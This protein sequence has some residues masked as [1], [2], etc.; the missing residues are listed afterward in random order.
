MHNSSS[1]AASLPRTYGI[2]FQM[3]VELPPAVGARNRTFVFKKNEVRNAYWEK[4]KQSCLFSSRNCCA[5]NREL[6]SGRRGIGQ[7]SIWRSF[8]I[9]RIAIR[10][11]SKKALDDTERAFDD[12]EGLRVARASRTTHECDAR[13]W[14]W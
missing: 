8:F 12:N 2:T 5:I 9:A 7:G 14:L 13:R 1:A 10:R 11:W 3:S 6:S 4:W